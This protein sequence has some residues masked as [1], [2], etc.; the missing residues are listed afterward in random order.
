MAQGGAVIVEYKV[1][2]NRVHGS[3]ML[4]RCHPGCTAMI[5]AC[6]DGRIPT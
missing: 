6:S 1:I 4:P 5:N 2:M 3:P